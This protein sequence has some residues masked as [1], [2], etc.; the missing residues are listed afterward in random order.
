MTAKRAPRMSDRDFLRGVVLTG[1]AIAFGVGASRYPIWE[2]GNTGPGLFPLIVSSILL[3]LGITSIARA[4][5]AREAP[6]KLQIRLRSIAIVV[7]SLCGFALLSELANMILGIFFLAFVAPL[8]S[9]P[10]SVKRS[11]ALALG[12]TAIAFVFRELLGLQL[13]LY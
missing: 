9:S 12:F 5:L 7:V 3:L 2:Y 10:Y 1:I 13:P 8:A 4:F 6:V 11:M